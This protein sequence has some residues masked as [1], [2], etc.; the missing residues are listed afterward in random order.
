MARDS[1]SKLA[2]KQ[3]IQSILLSVAHDHGGVLD[4][5]TPRLAVFLYAEGGGGLLVR[6]D[7]GEEVEH[8][9]VVDLY[10]A[11]ADR[12]CLVKAG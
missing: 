4:H 3:A 2:F 9:L 5:Y 10:V 12:N 8:H 11:D 7:G 1:P 6:G